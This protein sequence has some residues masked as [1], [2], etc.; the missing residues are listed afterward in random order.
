MN[1]IIKNTII[2]TVITLVSGL[3]LG[4]AYEVTKDPIAQSEENAKREAWQAVFPDASEDA[5]EQ[6]DVDQDIAASVKA[7]MAEKNLSQGG[8]GKQKGDRQFGQNKSDPL[9]SVKNVPDIV[10]GIPTASELK[11]PAVPV[12]TETVV[13]PVQ[14][15]AQQ[16]PAPL[17]VRESDSCEGKTVAVPVLSSVDFEGRQRSETVEIPQRV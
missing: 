17:P 13:N 14:E 9:G 10:K 3:L 11:L 8:Q 5:F 7:K 15:S 16:T 1:K 4:L 12:L 6:I 2:L